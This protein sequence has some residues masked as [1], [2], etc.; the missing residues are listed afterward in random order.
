MG[1][2]TEGG[3][4][5][6]QPRMLPPHPWH[7]FVVLGDSFSEGLDD[8]EPLSSGGY[9]GWADRVAE[10]LSNGVPDFSYANLAVRGQMLH[11]VFATQLGHAL[12]LQPDLVSLQAGGNDL[13]HPGADPDKLAAEVENA[14]E[15]FGARGVRVLIF[16]GPDSGRATV[17]GQFRSKIAIYNENLRGIAEHHGAVIADLWSMNELHDPGMWSPDRLHPSSLGHHA[18]AGMVLKTLNVPHVL[19][20]RSPKPMPTK[21]WKRA[22]AEDIVWA[23][24]YLVPWVVRGIRHESPTGGHGAKR[25]VAM[26]LKLPESPH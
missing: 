13:L 25:P 18:V 5:S 26:P 17:L 4:G 16:V 3:G 14:V 20:A 1:F 22:R 24:E 23:R 12:A 15:I 8:P 11:Q 10:E 7:R 21:S 6:G 19:E 2:E 9:R